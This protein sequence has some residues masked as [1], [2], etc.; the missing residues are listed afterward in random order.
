MRTIYSEYWL[1]ELLLSKYEIFVELH[2]I[3]SLNSYFK[4]LFRVV[5]ENG[6]EGRKFRKAVYLLLFIVLTWTLSNIG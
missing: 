2:V 5:D 6:K 4:I 3:W 1:L